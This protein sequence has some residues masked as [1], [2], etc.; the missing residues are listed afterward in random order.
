MYLKDQPW[1]NK[2][3]AVRS[4]HKNICH[5]ALQGEQTGKVG[6]FRPHQVANV[7][8]TPLPFCFAHG[9]TYADTGD[10]AVWVRGCGSGL[11]REE[12]VYCPDYIVC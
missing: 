12:A 9:P 7:D 1:S 4:F 11:A 10:K 5:I 8:Q 3:S 6:K 2:E